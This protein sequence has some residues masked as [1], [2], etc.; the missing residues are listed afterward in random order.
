MRVQKRRRLEG[1]TDYRNRIALLKGNLPRI[2]FRKTNK[3]IIGQY[4]ISKEA[5]DFVLS[6]A[7]STELLKY[8]WPKENSGSLKSLPASYLI[9]FLLGKK[10][11][12][13]KKGKNAVLDIGLNRNVKKSRIYSFLKG[14][15]DSGVEIPHNENVFPDEERISGKNTKIR[16]FREVFNKI[17]EKIEGGAL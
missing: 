8:G 2:A 3:K 13:S 14:V 1:K 4:I 7:N 11:G 5:Q 10:I 12:K 15:I 6:E 16:N 9:G 17:K